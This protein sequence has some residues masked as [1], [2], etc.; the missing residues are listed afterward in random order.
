MCLHLC[1]LIYFS[2]TEDQPDAEEKQTP[3][4]SETDGSPDVTMEVVQPVPGVQAVVS[5]VVSPSPVSRLWQLLRM[6]KHKLCII[7]L[8]TL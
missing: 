6:Y 1:A 2:S 7:H 3:T 5:P 4:P 8:W